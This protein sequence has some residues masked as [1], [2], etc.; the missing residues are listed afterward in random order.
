MNR[1]GAWRV[2]VVLG[3]AATLSLPSAG[4]AVLTY[5]F[6]GRVERVTDVLA[7]TFSVGDKVSVAVDV[8]MSTLDGSPGDPSIGDY[9][10]GV[11]SLSF[12]IGS[13]VG[14][15]QL[16]VRFKVGN[17]FSDG[18]DFVEIV[19]ANV[20][21]PSVGSRDPD[22]F[23]VQLRNLSGTALD[24]DGLPAA[25]IDPTAFDESISFTFISLTFEREGLVR[26]P[27]VSIQFTPVPLP[28][29]LG[30]L[31]GALAIVI[32]PSVRVRRGEAGR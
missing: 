4:A 17:D 8:E 29:A 24:S 14:S 11:S 21:A 30:L 28:P 27:S 26:S 10:N 32:A 5:D 15:A 13:Y 6:A 7:G 31:A 3:W 22:E 12:R 25:P 9:S 16:P 23:R 19:A 1:F 2:A 20:L 18:R